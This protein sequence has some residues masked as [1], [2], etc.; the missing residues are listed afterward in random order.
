MWEI[1]V[2]FV[3]GLIG[4]E[5]MGQ[6]SI[7]V[8]GL[9]VSYNEEG[10][11]SPIILIHGFCGSKKY[12][13][14]VIFKLADHFRVIAL[15]LPGHGESSNLEGNSSIED[16]ADHI[17]K[18]LDYLNVTK[19]TMFGHSLGGYVT[20]A[21]AEK[22]G[23]M[24][25]G[26][27][28]IHSTALPDSYEAKK[29]RDASVEKVE[30]DGIRA[31]IDG[32]IPKL[33]SPDNQDRHQKDIIKAKEIGYNTSSQGAMKTLVAMKNRPDRNF[34][35]EKAE[36]PILLLAGEKDQIISPEKTFSVNNTNIKP[37]VIKDSGHMSMY[38]NPA[39][40]INN[41]VEYMNSLKV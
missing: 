38:E 5:M 27:S 30:R 9:T 14:N 32:L 13:D 17:K 33:F 1:K 19:V 16:F 22:F 18:L 23:H 29:G 31:F 26:F 10:Q 24:L 3:L 15:D 7:H 25:N 40:L 12:W 21:F 11:G 2:N 34:I 35:L 28:L 4:G 36:I 20:L 8:N 37:V 41:I 39:E 6:N